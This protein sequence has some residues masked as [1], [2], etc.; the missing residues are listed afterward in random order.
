M[1]KPHIN[2]SVFGKLYPLTIH[3]LHLSDTLSNWYNSSE[4][5]NEIF[6]LDLPNEYQLAFDYVYQEFKNPGSFERYVNECIKEQIDFT[7]L[8]IIH[9]GIVANQLKMSAFS[10]NLLNYVRKYVSIKDCFYNWDLYQ[11]SQIIKEICIKKIM[12]KL[13]Y[14]DKIYDYKFLPEKIKKYLLNTEV[15]T[16]NEYKE[17]KL[18]FIRLKHI[19]NEYPSDYN[20][21]VLLQYFKKKYPSDYDNEEL[22]KYFKKKYIIEHLSNWNSSINYINKYTDIVIGGEKIEIF[23]PKQYKYNYIYTLG[24]YYTFKKRD[25][26]VMVEPKKIKLIN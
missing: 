19:N 11:H 20:N 21:E 7:S 6:P 8:M 16:I 10:T 5:Q 22:L 4:D 24:Y 17:N 25:K 15:K 18:N 26:F 9:T 2:I 12:F 1:T 3:Q 23:I 13:M 14:Q